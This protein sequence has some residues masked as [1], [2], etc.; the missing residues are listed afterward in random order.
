MKYKI[1]LLFL[2]VFSFS[3][4]AQETFND[5]FCE[6][7]KTLTKHVKKKEIKEGTSTDFSQNASRFI[8][9][10][11]DHIV[12]DLEFVK[13]YP[14]F[15]RNFAPAFS[16]K[17]ELGNSFATLVSVANVNLTDD[18][19]KKEIALFIND[20]SEVITNCECKVTEDEI[21]SNNIKADKFYRR[22]WDCGKQGKL[23]LAVSA[24]KLSDEVS[25]FISY[26]N[27]NYIAIY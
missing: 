24:L 25:Q 9:S 7:L 15:Q 19:T 16:G 10:Y 1:T 20:L 23:Y 13:G 8:S 4:K 17:K 26:I 11:N 3:M 27:F 18:K 5:Q 2:I 21:D 14:L 22:Q 12:T 6:A